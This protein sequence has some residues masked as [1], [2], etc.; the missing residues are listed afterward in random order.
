[1]IIAWP[2]EWADNGPGR[3]Q[4]G[5]ACVDTSIY[6]HPGRF[7]Y[8]PESRSI[9]NLAAI[10]PDMNLL[11]S[12]TFSCPF[13]PPKTLL[14]ALSSAGP[15][16]TSV[17]FDETPV[18]VGPGSDPLP[19]VPM[20]VQTLQYIAV[21]GSVRIGD[22]YLEPKYSVGI[23][24][25][26]EWKRK[27]D[28][29]LHQWD[30]TQT[31]HRNYIM[32]HAPTLTRLE[33]S[34]SLFSFDDLAYQEWPLLRCFILTGKIPTRKDYDLPRGNTSLEGVLARMPNLEDLRLLFSQT[35]E[36]AMKLAPCEHSDRLTTLAVSHI[37]DLSG[38]KLTSLQ[39]LAVLAITHHPRMPIALS[40]GDFQ[41]L[42]GALEEGG[43]TLTRFRIMLEDALTPQTCRNI[44]AC[45]P[46]LEDLEIELCVYP[47]GDCAHSK[48][49]Y[50][51]A[52]APLT[53]LHSL[54]ICAQFPESDAGS[55]PP[56]AERRKF[57]H[58]LAKSMPSLNSIGFEY[59]QRSGRAHDLW[60]DY[61]IV[62]QGDSID[63]EQLATAFYPQTSIWR[64]CY[65]IVVAGTR[66]M[67][68]ALV[69]PLAWHV[70][71]RTLL[72]AGMSSNRPPQLPLP[73]GEGRGTSFKRSFEQYGFDLDTTP[74][75]ESSG[76]GSSLS[77]S[78]ERDERNKRARSESRT[79]ESSGTSTSL[80]DE[81]S[82]S[83]SSSFMTAISVEQTGLSAAH[84][85]AVDEEL[86]AASISPMAMESSQTSS[87][88]DL[89]IPS[90]PIPSASDQVRASLQR[91]SAF[92][93]EISVL[94]RSPNVPS[95]LPPLTSLTVGDDPQLFDLD[96]ENAGV[97]G[98]Q[99]FELGGFHNHTTS[100]MLA[101]T[102]SH[103]STASRPSGTTRNRLSREPLSTL[104]QSSPDSWFNADSAINS[105][106][107]RLE[108]A[109]A[110]DYMPPR[111]WFD[112]YPAPGSDGSTGDDSGTPSRQ[113]LSSSI[114]TIIRLLE[115]E[116]RL[117][118]HPT[119]SRTF[120]EDHGAHGSSLP[121]TT[122][123]RSSELSLSIILSHAYPS[124]YA[125]E[126]PR[127]FS[128]AEWP[129]RSSGRQVPPEALDRASSGRNRDVLPSIDTSDFEVDFPGDTHDG[130]TGR[131]DSSDTGQSCTRK[132]TTHYSNITTDLR[133]M[134]HPPL[135][136]R[137][138]WALPGMPDTRRSSLQAHSSRLPASNSLV[139]ETAAELRRTASRSQML[140][141]IPRY[142]DAFEVSSDFDPDAW[143]ERQLPATTTRRETDGLS[144][145]ERL[146]SRIRNLEPPTGPR[147][148]APPSHRVDRPEPPSQ[149]RYDTASI[150]S[151]DQHGPLSPSRGGA[152]RHS[153]VR[154]AGVT[155][156]AEDSRLIR[157][158][159]AA[160][161]RASLSSRS[162]GSSSTS[163]ILPSSN[164]R[165]DQH[166]SPRHR[167]HSTH[168]DTARPRDLESHVDRLRGMTAVDRTQD[169][170]R[171]RARMRAAVADVGLFLSPSPPPARGRDSS[172]TAEPPRAAT[173]SAYDSIDLSGYH[174]GPFRASLQRS[175]DL[176]R[177]RSRL[178]RRD[179][180]DEPMPTTS[181]STRAAAPPSLPPSRFDSNAIDLFMDRQPRTSF[182]TATEHPQS[183]GSD[184]N[185]NFPHLV[186][187]AR[188]GRSHISER[189]ALPSSQG[190]GYSDLDSEEVPDV[191]VERQRWASWRSRME[192]MSTDAYSALQDIPMEQDSTRPYQHSPNSSLRNPASGDYA[193]ETR[194]LPPSALFQP[195]ATNHQ[196]QVR[197]RINS[198]RAQIRPSV[199]A[200]SPTHATR[201]TSSAR[202]SGASDFR[203]S[204]DIMSADGLSESTNRSLFN[205]Y[206]EVN[207]DRERASALE[208]NSEA[209]S[210]FWASRARYARRGRLAAQDQQAPEPSRLPN[211]HPPRLPP[212]NPLTV[213]GRSSSISPARRSIDRPSPST[214]ALNTTRARAARA[215]AH[216]DRE[217]FM[218]DFPRFDVHHFTHRAGR[219][220]GDY[221]RDEDF[222]SSYESLMTLAST[223]GEVRP[224]S[225]PS[226][227]I[228]SLPTG[229]YQD[230]R[231]PGS[232]ERCP[233]CLDDNLL[234]LS[235][236]NG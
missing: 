80:S 226:H 35:T 204:L 108:P 157:T 125:L 131:L 183:S 206:M 202:R 211:P 233:I 145:L 104:N 92:D 99:I 77:A 103:S 210:R 135:T 170:L 152:V 24:F 90:S 212:L 39:R 106:S 174:P 31:L 192:T 224:R 205:R 120:S 116:E 20:P 130:Y 32:S 40:L 88:E 186:R 30:F 218:S 26:P 188:L 86:F 38:L 8:E 111:D 66:P 140:P 220:A 136:H 209:S 195:P 208:E 142:N 160:G 149:L 71:T 158:L 139:S 33:I 219:N 173:S 232:D 213:Q 81:S 79:A 41:K 62:R 187:E 133:N 25:Q 110:T 44:A 161:R 95:S 1:M 155:P 190:Y 93:E 191:R 69:G 115:D 167:L 118:R 97:P 166:S 54:R 159:S 128:R 164:D 124:D 45:C 57:A 46:L 156:S 132:P 175:L 168:T 14:M 94:R 144:D 29:R 228:A 230:W 83:G 36:N 59:R 52:L 154:R 4:W 102:N 53:H 123:R 201:S 109:R 2:S 15:N 178:N 215:R 189:D 162:T 235:D 34:G 221:V 73:L 165:S 127:N 58:H 217:F 194:A 85:I 49:A 37:C 19:V 21:F 107:F 172:L 55:T 153:Y 197:E 216:R 13:W 231:T 101:E 5:Q 207:E 163:S 147:Y 223:L 72:P 7:W 61:E 151:S 193:T 182:G 10:I 28:Q 198:L 119:P 150:N 143:Y 9:E 78:S 134:R 148:D 18:S 229:T 74:D 87:Q 65:F 184:P 67:T 117:L 27:H 181:A 12:V 126:A 76:S 222:D 48:E 236:S 47:G 185:L 180:I 68:G 51:E 105:S 234:I 129:P 70:L 179:S 146:R 138:Q 64:R 177:I 11:S 98:L 56:F 84:P 227:V 82:V 196:A 91:F 75:G 114:S 96:E 6:P 89:Q 200:S 60:V 171:S 23:Y 63:I 169:E 203:E 214:A 176:D 100:A 17:T 22:G 112:T 50:A 16:L 225:T 121:E 122:N 42:L 199:G 3:S 141:S 43:A 113:Q 137:S